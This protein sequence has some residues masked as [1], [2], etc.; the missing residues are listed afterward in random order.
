MRP[1][2][3]LLHI[4]AFWRFFCLIRKSSIKKIL[5]KFITILETFS[6]LLV[7]IEVFKMLLFSWYL[8]QFKHNFTLHSI[9]WSGQILG[10]IYHCVLLSRGCSLRLH[11]VN[12]NIS[13]VQQAWNLAETRYRC[14]FHLWSYW[15]SEHLNFHISN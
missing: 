10:S 1:L 8:V 12:Y 2:L 7:I 3:R 14:V 9:L 13:E 15:N 5:Y 6:K 4:S 11:R